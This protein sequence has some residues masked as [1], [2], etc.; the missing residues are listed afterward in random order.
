[1]GFHLSFKKVT[2][3]AIKKV[4]QDDPRVRTRVLPSAKGLIVAETQDMRCRNKGGTLE[5]RSTCRKER[6]SPP[7]L[8]VS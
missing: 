6:A 5:K 8:R 1:M 7:D 2:G 3:L 4:H